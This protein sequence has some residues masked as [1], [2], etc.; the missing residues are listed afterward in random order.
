MLKIQQEEGIFLFTTDTIT[1]V[2]E[3][4]EY[5]GLVT[6]SAIYGGSFLKDWA[7]GIADKIGGRVRGYESALDD[8]VALS[9]RQM[10]RQAKKEGANAVIAI[11]IDHGVVN[12][13]MLRAN[14]YGTAIR[15]GRKATKHQQGQ[16]GD[17][18][19]D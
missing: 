3:I 7:A 9:L 6:G 15:F 19:S 4:Q 18:A 2:I 1:G 14:C 11:R 17:P 8:A 16:D 5:F 13:R 10:A 12:N